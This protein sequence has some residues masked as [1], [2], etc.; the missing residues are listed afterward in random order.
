MQ[1][2]YNEQ[3]L[4]VTESEIRKFNDY[5]K[6]NNAE[7]YLTLG[8]PDFYTPDQ[9]VN[10]TIE[11]LNN[12]KTKYGPTPGNLSL[13]KKICEFEKKFNKLNYNPNEVLITQGSTEAITSALFTILNPNDEVII[14]IPA[15]PM[16]AEIVKYQKA[17]VIN[18]D[19]SSNNFQ[20]TKEMLDNAI[21]EKTKCIILTSPNNPTGSILSDES[22][23]NVYNAV[24]D[25]PI[26]IICDD[27]YNQIVYKDKK[28]GFVKYQDLKDRIIVCQSYSKS[29]AMPG[30]RCGY[31]LASEEFVFHAKKIHQYMI[32]ALNTFIQDGMEVAFDID[33]QY[34]IDSYKMRRDYIYDRLV[35]M[36]LD[37]VL[38]DGAF[39]IFPSIK[40]LNI[41]SM[42]FCKRLVRDYKVA[43]IPGYCFSNDN[44]IRISY[45]VSMDII[46]IACDRIEEFVNKLRNENNKQ[47]LS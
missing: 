46:K 37:V 41:S 3:I 30:W 19:T 36:G 35:K 44:F 28:P 45:C 18:I 29:Y 21:N 15:Y 24:K 4:K 7:Y 22:L 9:I 20:I 34:M 25:K 17:N 6:E 31:M 26:F 12:H 38:P 32:V 16:Y 2:K 23:E 5:A 33:N 14:P 11:A 47:F 42:E 10:K 27:V 43:I 8:E 39:Y 13:R 1:L 40:K